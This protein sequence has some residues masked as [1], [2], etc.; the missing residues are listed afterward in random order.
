MGVHPEKKNQLTKLLIAATISVVIGTLFLWKGEGTWKISFEHYIWNAGYSLC[1]GLSLF[2]NGMI[3]NL[4]ERKYIS[5]KQYPVKSVFIALFFH[6][7]YS[8]V[9]IFIWNWLWFIVL[10]QQTW[11][12]FLEYGWFILG[13]EFVVLII[14]T[15]IIYAISFFKEWLEEVIQGEKLKQEA[16]ALQY[17]VMQ[18]QVNP[19]FLFNSLNALGSLI[20]IDPKKAKEFIRE[21]SMF[22]RELLYF[23]DKELVPVSE[24]LRFV[25]KYIYLQKIRFESNFDV[26]IQVKD[27]NSYEI[28]PMSLQMMIENAIKH[29]II[30]K[31]KPLN[32]IIG[33]TDDSELFVENN[34][35]LRENV[36]DSNNIGLKNLTER[37]RF[38]TGKEMIVE[39]NDKFFRVT[40]PLI[41]LKL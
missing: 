1:I 28:I 16:I 14:I 24:E 5:W 21:L 15:A 11:S 41:N 33:Q 9:V 25:Q 22:Y 2:A 30:S 36:T 32:I 20:D 10:K 40:I 27:E 18:N 26:S 35:Q 12:Q 13:G 31:E 39:S 17:Q 23:K 8:S 7:I 29:N 37:Y 19:H 6:L 4:V 3:F 34:L 38:L